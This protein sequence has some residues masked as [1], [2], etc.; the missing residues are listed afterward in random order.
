MPTWSVSRPPRPYGAKS[1]YYL[2]LEPPYVSKNGNFETVEE[3][4]WV[5]GFESSPLIPRLNQWLTVQTTGQVINLN[6]APLEVLLAMGFAR[7]LAQNIIM[8]RRAM[9]LRN[10]QEI[11]QANATP[12]LGQ[13]MQISFKSS[14]FFTIS[15]TGMVKK[16][17]GRQTIKAIVRIDA[18]PKAPWVILSWYS[19]FPG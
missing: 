18:N 12:L 7:D 2:N 19:G 15:S 5:R 17:S 13:G 1:A 3:L 8:A 4:A 9:P 6:T 11:P 10:L 14:P 16:N